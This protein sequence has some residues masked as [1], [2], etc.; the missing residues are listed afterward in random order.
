MTEDSK[1]ITPTVTGPWWWLRLANRQGSRRLRRRLVVGTYVVWLL[2]AAIVKLADPNYSGLSFL[3]VAT[4]LL[5]L[6]WLGGRRYVDTPSLAGGK[7]D[8]RLNEVGN[9][10]MKRAY[11]IFT[12]IVLTAW[13]LSLVALYWQPNDAGRVNAN[14]IWVAA[15]LLGT[16][17]PTVIVAW[18]EPDPVEPEKLPA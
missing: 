17:L 5:M 12:P 9:L 1:R 16:T 2:L 8:E 6:I 4:L 14:L 11:Q 18:R 7:L 3:L 13:P 10:A 15:F